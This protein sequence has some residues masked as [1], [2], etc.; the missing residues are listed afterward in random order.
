MRQTG[1]IQFV[2][3]RL[4]FLQNFAGIFAAAKQGDA[5]NSSRFAVQGE[6]AGGECGADADCADIADDDGNAAGG[7]QHDVLDV[8][9]I[10]NP[11]DAADHH[12]LLVGI[13]LCAAGIAVV[14]TERVVN[15]F[16]GEAEFLERGRGE[17][18]LIL[19]DEPAEGHD[20]GDA[21]NLEKARADDP[22]LQLAKLHVVEA[23]AF[24]A[25]AVH[26]ADRRGERGDV[27]HDALGEVGAAQTFEDYLAGEV[28]VG[29][30][31][32]RDFDD[33]QAVN[34][35][36][37]AR[38]HIGNA[39]ERALDRD[40]DLL[41][42]LLGRLAGHSGDHDDLGIRDIGVGF[43]LQL[44]EGIEAQADEGDRENDRDEAL[45]ERKS[46]DSTDHVVSQ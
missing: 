19:F 16:H 41:L 2:H 22:V 26:F 6:G 46:Q 24:Q 11:S 13:E 27:R 40:G 38:N 32:K 44:P 45:F 33:G 31:G 35:A 20:V 1:G 15:L 3:G 25:E 21:G 23:A 12:G 43:D 4:Q 39:V 30:V 7:G 9:D 14:R 5:L 34:G 10:V 8:G 28:I 37:P 17:F 42:H 18:D 36:R 29:V